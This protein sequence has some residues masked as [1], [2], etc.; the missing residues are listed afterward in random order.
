MTK[1]LHQLI[2]R[3]KAKVLWHDHGHFQISAAVRQDLQFLF[4]YLSNRSNPW[5]VWRHVYWLQH[6][7]LLTYAQVLLRHGPT[8]SG[9][10]PKEP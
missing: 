1:H 3:A 8:P 5:L 10:S 9:N 6:G 4:T 7:F 2:S